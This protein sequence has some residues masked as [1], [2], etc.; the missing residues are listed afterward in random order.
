MH[1]RTT[2]DLPLRL[3][4][5]A[6]RASGARTKTEAIILGLK[7]LTRRKKIE[8]LWGLRGRIPMDLDL[9]KARAR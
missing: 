3:L 5:A 1:M 6:C 4:E 9:D 2:L 7:E 8:R